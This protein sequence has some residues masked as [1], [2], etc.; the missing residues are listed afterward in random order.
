[1]A[2]TIEVLKADQGE[3][4]EYDAII[5]D[6]DDNPVVYQGNEPLT[7]LIWPGDD[8]APFTLI[9]SV[10]SWV[11]AP[12]SMV[13]IHFGSVDTAS[14][15]PGTYAGRVRVQVGLNVVGIYQFKLDL[16]G[17]P[18]TAVAG[19]VYCT[20]DDMR[21]IAHW[22]ERLQD[23]SDLTGFAEQRELA[24]TWLDDAILSSYRPDLRWTGST[25]NDAHFSP[26]RFGYGLY[27][28]LPPDRWLQDRLDEG[29]LIVKPWVKEATARYAVALVCEAVVGEGRN[30]SYQTLGIRNMNQAH[31]LAMSRQALIDLP[32][33]AGVRDGWPE[34]WVRLGTKSTR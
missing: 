21:R 30:T 3:V 2:E 12:T 20:L 31:N 8:Q 34:I 10:A 22:I 16:A 27:G 14:W 24:R 15:T 7:L 23:A 1:M 28:D 25:P 18:G 4:A 11:G 9:D 19:K 5:L 6:G 33:A 26:T 29:S 17:Q 13:R 32:N